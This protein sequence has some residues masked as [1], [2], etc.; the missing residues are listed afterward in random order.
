MKKTLLF[1]TLF[2]TLMFAKELQNPTYTLQSS[3]SVTDII[4][5]KGKLY[6]AT[7]ASTLDIFDTNTHK[8]VKQI[9]VEQIT[10]F[11]GDIIDSKIY[12]VDLLK[13]KLM[14]LSLGNKGARR[15]HIYQDEKLSL[16]LSDKE[17]LYIAKAKFLDE[18]TILLALLSNE[19]ISYDIEKQKINYRFQ[20]SQ[21]KFSNFVLNEDKSEVVV[22]DESGDLKLHKTQNGKFIKAFNGQN[23]DNVFQ[24]D[25]KKGIIATAG[26]DRRAVIYNTNSDSS[27][28]KTASFLIYSVGLSP[29]GNIAGFASDES[30][31]VTLFKVSTKSD[32]A[33]L[34]KNK[35]T[36]TNILFISEKELFISSDDKVIN[37]YKLK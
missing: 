18:H 26:Q 9:K 24:V 28:Y 37:F 19:L 10:D 27:Y 25:Y 1:L 15:V 12:S 23:L 22:A 30:N 36:I 34:T 16:V 14:L 33:T 2:T 32:L 6:S 21:S 3:G 4:Y 35:M 11:M 7:D 29:S 31:N 20:V 13:D 8:I 5:N 17:G